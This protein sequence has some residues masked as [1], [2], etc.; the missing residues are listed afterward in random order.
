MDRFSRDGSGCLLGGKRKQEWKQ[1]EKLGSTA[2]FQVR[3]D[4]AVTDLEW[5]LNNLHESVKEK[6]KSKMTPRFWP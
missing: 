1:E 5:V 6:E 3:E 2:A 4:G